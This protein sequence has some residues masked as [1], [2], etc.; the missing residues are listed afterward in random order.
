MALLILK[1]RMSYA[2]TG[3]KAGQVDV[4]WRKHVQLL[5]ARDGRCLYEGVRVILHYGTADQAGGADGRDGCSVPCIT[6]EC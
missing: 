5:Q 2:E 1:H 3:H 4:A 6:K